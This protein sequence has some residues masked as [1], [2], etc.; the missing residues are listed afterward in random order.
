M[1]AGRFTACTQLGACVSMRN[2]ASVHAD[3]C[4]VVL[5]LQATAACLSSKTCAADL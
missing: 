3:G 2:S 4:A 1:A 5:L